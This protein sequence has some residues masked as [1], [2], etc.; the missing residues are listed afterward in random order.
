[1]YLTTVACNDQNRID[2]KL[3]GDLMVISTGKSI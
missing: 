1:M 3:K 2:I